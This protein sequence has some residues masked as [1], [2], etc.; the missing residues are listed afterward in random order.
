MAA[1]ELRAPAAV[2]V[3]ATVGV[4]FA[5]YPALAASRLDPIEAFRYQ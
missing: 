3:Y 2:A 4:V 5:L 1:Q